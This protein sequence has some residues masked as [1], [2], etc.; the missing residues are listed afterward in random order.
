[1]IKSVVFVLLIGLCFGCTSAPKRICTETRV[2]KG[3]RCPHPEH[4]KFFT[5]DS[6]S[7]ELG[8]L[9]V[10]YRCKCL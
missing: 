10:I 3:Q 4:T 6:G 8:E 2:K 9:K 7:T 5:Y 1:M